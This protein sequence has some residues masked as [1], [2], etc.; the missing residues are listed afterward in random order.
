M[1][2]ALNILASPYLADLLAFREHERILEPTNTFLLRVQRFEYKRWGDRA[3]SSLHPDFLRI[4][5]PTLTCATLNTNLKYFL[6]RQA[7]NT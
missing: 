1:F 3:S 4:D 6:F 5:A 7:F 2:K